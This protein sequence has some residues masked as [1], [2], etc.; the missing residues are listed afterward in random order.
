MLR[1]QFLG[2]DLYGCKE[3]LGRLDDYLDRELSPDEQA[4]VRTHLRICQECA[5]KFSFEDKL[6]SGVRERVNKEL[7]PDDV[8][9][10][11]AKI[12]ALL[13]QEGTN[14]PEA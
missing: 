4:K 5:R 12:A 8:T 14:K 2:L 7:L 10:L 1:V 13:K 9:A 11:Q 3:A 6:N